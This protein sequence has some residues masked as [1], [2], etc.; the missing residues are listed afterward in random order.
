MLILQEYE[1]K[2]GKKPEERSIEE[3]REYG[4]L[5]LDKPRGPTSHETSAFARKL[6]GAKKSG[7][8]GT[9]DADVSGVLP[10]LFGHACKIST[11]L[12]KEDKEYVCIMR[13]GAT[14]ADEEL[15]EAFSRFRGRIYQKPPEA[16]AVAKKLRIRNV[17]SLDILERDGKDILFKAKVQHGTYIRNICFDIGE[18]LGVGAEMFELRRTKSGGFSEKQAVTLQDFSDRLWLAQECGNEKPLREC[19]LPME[20]AL[21]L[22]KIFVDDGALKPLS[23]GADLAVPGILRLDDDIARG[24]SVQLL[25]DKGEL[26]CIATALMSAKEMQTKKN[27]VACDV[28]RVIRSFA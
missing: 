23:S 24:D 22:R 5:P 15:R 18:V 2:I 20:R 7:H 26:V 17:Y 27:G 4:V 6:L 3:L 12:T 11:I 21:H 13:L 10:V 1:G 9:L 19:L 14:V 25:S 8:S 16:S 28:E